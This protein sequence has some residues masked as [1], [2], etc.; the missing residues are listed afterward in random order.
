M[1]EKTSNTRSGALQEGS[2]QAPWNLLVDLSRQQLA[3]SAELVSAIYRGSEALRKIQQ[4]TAHQASTRYETLV[5]KLSAPCQPADLMALQ[6]E[7]LRVDLQSAGQY[8]QQLVAA[9]LQT[10]REMMGSM[11]HMLDSDKN[12]GVKSALQAIQTIIPPM[13][14]SFYVPSPGTVDDQHRDS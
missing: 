9:G 5:Q 2:N 7:L 13:A 3:T 14:S 10:Q 4:D 6:S 11:S 12:G 1:R 8:W